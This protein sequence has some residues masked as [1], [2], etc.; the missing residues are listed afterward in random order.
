[1][2]IQGLSSSRISVEKTHNCA[3][4]LRAAYDTF[5]LEA[6]RSQLW[7]TLA[8]LENT[9]AEKYNDFEGSPLAHHLGILY[10]IHE[11]LS[12]DSH[13]REIAM[14]LV[15]R[16]EDLAFYSGIQ[17]YNNEETLC[18]RHSA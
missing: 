17:T 1:M 11:A 2:R 6:L 8:G 14:E 9:V 15:D 13:T 5:D 3:A 7:E 12:Q 16:V 10:Q 18:A 4:A